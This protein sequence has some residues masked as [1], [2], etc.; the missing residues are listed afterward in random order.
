MEHCK[1]QHE[2]DTEVQSIALDILSDYGDSDDYMDGVNEAVDGHQW[3]IYTY[4]AQQLC[5]AIDT[6]DGE[7][8]LCELDSKPFSDCD[9]FA[10]VNTMLAYACLYVAVITA[11][12]TLLNAKWQ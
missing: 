5:A 6:D 3:V 8:W 7:E 1:T 12:E 2:F 4:K 10:Q 11:V 9:T